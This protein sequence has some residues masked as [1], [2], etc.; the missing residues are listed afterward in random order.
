[1]R[2]PS[3]SRSALEVAG[4]DDHRLL[5]LEYTVKCSVGAWHLGREWNRL[6]DP[7][8]RARHLAD[9]QG[10]ERVTIEPQRLSWIERHVFVVVLV[11]LAVIA[12][13]LWGGFKVLQST[14]PADEQVPSNSLSSQGVATIAAFDTGDVP[15][16]ARLYPHESESEI[17]AV[18]DHC[19]IISPNGRENVPVDAAT[20]ERGRVVLRGHAR[21]DP[22]RKVGCTFWLGWDT[23]RSDSFWTVAY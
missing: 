23:E 11:S 20:P 3:G 12:G 10:D 8:P 19:A 13:C 2:G 17:R 4:A 5:R 18:W 6:G 14:L 9:S 1:L 15:A 21:N 22:H 7:A 16:L